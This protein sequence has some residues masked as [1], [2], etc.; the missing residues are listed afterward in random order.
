MPSTLVYGIGAIN[1]ALIKESNTSKFLDSERYQ[2]FITHSEPNAQLHVYPGVLGELRA[3]TP[4]MGEDV[5]WQMYRDGE[6]WNFYM[7][8]ATSDLGHKAIF[9]HDFHSGQVYL[10]KDVSDTG[11]Y[12]FPLNIPMGKIYYVNLLAQGYGVMMHSCGIN[13]DGQGQLFAGFGGA[14]KSTTA[15]LWEGENGVRVFNDD[16]I[17][18]R[19]I[20]GEFTIFGT[21]WPGRGG[22]ALPDSVPIDKIFILRQAPQNEARQLSPI[23]AASAMLARSFAPHWDASAMDFTLGFLSDLCQKVPVYELSFLPDKS[24]VEYVRCL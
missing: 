23:K 1:T 3:W 20:N 5:N 10:H 8:S 11:A 4:A 13:L 18:L 7:R 24:I 16:C 17:I 19:K 22:N 12:F 6:N 21:P 9:G 15:G 2:P 14:G